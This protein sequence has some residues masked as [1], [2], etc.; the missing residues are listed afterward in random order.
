MVFRGDDFPLSS[1][2]RARLNHRS[3]GDD[4]GEPQP[5]R[6]G[7]RFLEHETPRQ[8]A[9]YGKDGDIDPQEPGEVPILP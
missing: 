2:P 7:N 5:G 3:A 1:Q 8:N 6:A 9:H 4:E